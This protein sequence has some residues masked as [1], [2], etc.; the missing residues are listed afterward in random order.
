MFRA[1]PFLRRA[2]QTSHPLLTCQATNESRYAGFYL[3]HTTATAPVDTLAAG[4]CAGLWGWHEVSARRVNLSVLSGAV[5]AASET[6]PPRCDDISHRYPT[7]WSINCKFKSSGRAHAKEVTPRASGAT[8]TETIATDPVNPPRRAAT[9]GK[10]QDKKKD[11]QAA[12]RG[13][14]KTSSLAYL[15]VLGLG[16][17]VPDGIVPSVYLFMDQCRM[18]FNVGEGLQRYCVQHQV[19]LSKVEDIFLTRITTQAAG[20]LPGMLLTLADMSPTEEPLHVKVDAICFDGFQVD[21][22]RV[23]IL[24]DSYDAGNCRSCYVD[25]GLSVA[26]CTA[27]PPAIGSH[28]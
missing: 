26:P 22:Q 19:K 1:A 2:P 6:H 12:T 27:S 5:L 9:M 17:D 8:Q 10:K 28:A 14:N 4:R 23:L 18:I 11:R 21:Y 15:Q 16:T 3:G 7:P 20:G 25:R 13:D 24:R